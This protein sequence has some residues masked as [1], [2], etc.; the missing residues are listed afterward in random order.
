[1]AD[2]NH[3]VLRL[4]SRPR[5]LRSRQHIQGAR[6]FALVMVMYVSAGDDIPLSMV[7]T[8]L[9]QPDLVVLERNKRVVPQVCRV[10]QGVKI[11]KL[12]I[13]PPS[14]VLKFV[15]E[16]C[17]SSKEHRRGEAKTRNGPSLELWQWS[18]S[19]TLPV[20]KKTVGFLVY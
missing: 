1:M 20:Q 4:D 18:T 12:F 19:N 9:V 13:S 10:Y 17:L 14:L 5:M 15:V 11:L 8:L 2:A 3:R 16:T 7:E 6:R